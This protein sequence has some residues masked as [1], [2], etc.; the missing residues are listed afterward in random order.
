MYLFILRER[1]SMRVGKGQ[2]ER[3][4]QNPKQALSCQHRARHGAQ[5]HEPRDRDLSRS[6]TLNRLSHP[7]APEVSFKKLFMVKGIEATLGTTFSI[8]CLS[9]IPWPCAYTYQ[10]A[11]GNV[12]YCSDLLPDSEFCSF[13]PNRAGT[14]LSAPSET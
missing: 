8:F 6:Q 2:R 1:V 11:A 5:T 7:G 13:I 3:E 12:I 14:I 9:L 10:N 4:R